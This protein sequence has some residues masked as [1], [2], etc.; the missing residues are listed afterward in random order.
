MDLN[1]ASEKVQFG[2]GN[3]ISNFRDQQQIINT[4]IESS[5]CY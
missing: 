2:G 1:Q 3:F 5:E 4:G